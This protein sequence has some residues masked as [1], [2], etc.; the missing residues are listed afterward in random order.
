MDTKKRVY[1]QFQQFKRLKSLFNGQKPDL[2]S[3]DVSSGTH[4]LEVP[5]QRFFKSRR[6]SNED[7]N[8]L[9]IKVLTQA[10]ANSHSII[11]SKKE[12]VDN[13]Y[14]SFKQK[15]KSTKKSDPH[16]PMTLIAAQDMI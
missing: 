15:R 14:H 6:A 4:T 9:D 5:P 13:K 10:P 7:T 12:S 1:K 8:T 16:M 3:I 11:V 2:N